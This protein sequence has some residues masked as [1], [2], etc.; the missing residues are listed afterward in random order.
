MEENWEM[1]YGDVVLSN[2][3]GKMYQ[4]T[5]SSKAVSITFVRKVYQVVGL[6][7]QFHFD[8]KATLNN[9]GNELHG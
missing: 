9:N 3:G 5:V 2:R 1:K 4:L 8:Y 7:N 6:E